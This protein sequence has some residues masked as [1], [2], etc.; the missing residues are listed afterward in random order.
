MQHAESCVWRHASPLALLH[1]WRRPARLALP[2]PPRFC[3]S[4]YS[5]S[6]RSTRSGSTTIRHRRSRQR[7]SRVFT[8]GAIS[9]SPAQ[10]VPVSATAMPEITDERQDLDHAPAARD[11]LYGRS[12]VR[13]QAARAGRRRHRLL[14]EARARSELKRGGNAA[15]PKSW[16]GA[17]AVSM[18]PSKTG[19]ASTTTGRSKACARSTATPCRFASSRQISGHRELRH[20]RQRWRAKSSRRR[21]ATRDAAGRDG[22]VQVARVAAGFE[23]RARRQSL[24]SDHRFPGEQRPARCRPGAQHAGR[25]APANRRGR[26]QRHRGGADARPAIRSR[27]ARLHVVLPRSLAQRAVPTAASSSQNTSSGG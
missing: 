1:V 8:T 10:L 23:D 11:P 20:R 6:R 13:G 16:S 3:G 24:L 12:G 26:A 17:R 14:D 22:T 9:A 15:S 4:R 5:T 18:P 27:Q 7:S 19:H 2:I 21:V 25:R